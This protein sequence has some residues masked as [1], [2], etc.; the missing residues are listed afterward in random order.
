MKIAMLI[1]T[2]FPPEEG[3]GNH[4]YN[5]SKK[6]VEN[7]H[8]ITVFTRGS[9]KTEVSQFEDIKIVK[10][11][12]I[13]LYPFHIKIHGF[14]LKRALKSVEPEF[15]IIHA[16]TPLTPN[17]TTSVPFILTFHSSLVEAAKKM[18]IVDLKSLLTKIMTKTVTYPILVNSI[19]NSEAVITVSKLTRDELI[20]YFGIKN[21]IVIGNAVDTEFFKPS[22]EKSG[23]YLLYV[24][25]LSYDKGLFEL[26]EAADI[27]CK[28]NNIKL[29]LVGK[30]EL[31]KKL[32]E[33]VKLKGLEN[34]VQFAGFKQ[35]DE[36]IKIY[37]N[38][39]I[40]ISSS[41]YESGPITV[42]EAMACGKPVISTE[43]GIAS[44]C[45]SNFENGILIPPGS[46]QKIIDALNL[47]LKDEDLMELLGSNASKTI[48]ENY[49]WDSI[50]K[51][52]E[53]IYQSN[54]R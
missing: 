19:K 14:F 8:E 28:Q 30:G 46:S 48:Q 9:Y 42:L 17:I 33:K 1:S 36:L 34:H 21:I 49:T 52:V 27:V 20:K 25:R 2:S 38:S 51:M 32:Q 43:V 29:I 16:H 50:T 35:R 40:F 45:I 22:K 10:V 15:D 41:T 3:I 11:P 6:L 7:G 12:F 39:K 47:V 26:I 44:E 31:Y 5:L 18:K 4:V 23:N 37:Q 13:P 24:G 53:N 54:K